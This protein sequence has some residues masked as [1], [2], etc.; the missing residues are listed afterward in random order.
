MFKDCELGRFSLK[1]DQAAPYNAF[2]ELANMQEKLDLKGRANLVVAGKTSIE[3]VQA[4]LG[5]VWTLDDAGLTLRDVK[6]YGI[7]QLESPRIYL[8]PAVADAAMAM[9]R[10][11]IGALT[12]L[13][14]SITAESGKST[15]YS[16]MTAIS[17]S[18]KFGPVP[19]ALKADEIVISQWLADELSV[20]K[21]DS[22][23]VAYSELTAGESYQEKTRSFRVASV[24]KTESLAMEKALVPDFPS[25]TDVESCKDWDVDL[26]MDE[27]KLEDEANEAYWKKYRQTPKALV[28]LAAGREM[29]GN[30]Y[31]EL[32]SVRFAESAGVAEALRGKLSPAV[33]GLSFLPVREEALRS[34]TES[35]DLGQLFLGMSFFIIIASLLLTAMLFTFLVEQRAREMG[36]LLAAG[37]DSSS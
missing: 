6:A 21:G 27:E 16:F 34:V 24:V 26:P 15:P 28:T 12:Y 1:S 20:G 30:R 22:V 10:A 2:I 3:A 13:V 29:W 14:N 32:M 37:T 5:E 7:T 23:K 33:V 9:S 18:G 8:D 31:G 25:L 17:P 4:K 35:M 19:A 36:V 11:P